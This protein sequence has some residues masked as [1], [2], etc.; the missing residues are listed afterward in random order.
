MHP[1]ITQNIHTGNGVHA[2][3]LA[4]LTSAEIALDQAIKQ[5]MS[6]HGARSSEFYKQKASRKIKLCRR[7]LKEMW[8]V[9]SGHA[10]SLH[11]V[12]STDHD[13]DNNINDDANIASMAT[14][15]NKNKAKLAS[16]DTESSRII[17]ERIKNGEMY[18]KAIWEGRLRYYWL[19][20]QL[21]KLNERHSQSLLM[22]KCCAVT[23]NENKIL[24][25]NNAIIG[26]AEPTKEMYYINH[27]VYSNIIDHRSIV[28]RLDELASKATIDR[29]IKFYKEGVELDPNA[30][31][32]IF[33]ASVESAD[34]VV[35]SSQQNLNDVERDQES[36]CV[37]KRHYK[38]A[39]TLVRKHI[40]RIKTAIFAK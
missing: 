23:L 40:T 5:K 17:Y 21:D 35:S 36:G 27:C 24:N 38:E 37:K 22:L 2:D 13:R 31:N 18:L 39:G 14:F 7:C 16:L 6:I 30:P 11:E 32:R 4:W 28:R 12:Q 34:P 29:A 1:G 15:L 9:L 19:C 20:A 10:M 26:F 25:G 8:L 3:A 33:P